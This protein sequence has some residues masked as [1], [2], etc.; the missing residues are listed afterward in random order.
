[1]AM[2]Y[3]SLGSNINREKNIRQAEIAL[4]NKFGQ[5]EYSPVYETEAVGFDGDNFYNSVLAFETEQSV[6]DVAHVLKQI[7]DNIGR[8]RS[9]AKFSA[10]VID[11]DL[12]LYDDLILKADGIHIPREEILYNAFVLKPLFDIAAYRLHPELHKSFQ[13]IWYE[14]NLKQIKLEEITL[15]RAAH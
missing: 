7:E 2:V 6:H 14:S 11:L 13:T 4:E 15:V 10:R 1:M 9:Q 8:D 12:L 5:L 3:I